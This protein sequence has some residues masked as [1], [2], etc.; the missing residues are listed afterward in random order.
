M[1]ECGLNICE[2]NGTCV[3]HV[4]TFTRM[5]PDGFNGAFCEEKGSI[6]YSSLTVRFRHVMFTSKYLTVAVVKY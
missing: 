5:C 2:N 6:Y 4:A 3:K 1:S